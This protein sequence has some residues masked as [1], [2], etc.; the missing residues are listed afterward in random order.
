MQDAQGQLKAE[1]MTLIGK[2]EQFEKELS[3]AQKL[4]SLHKSHSDK[5]TAEAAELESVVR[6]LRQHIEVSL[7]ACN[8]ITRLAC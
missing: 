5:R 7:P 4:A 6:D 1:Q 8:F 3:V 2:E